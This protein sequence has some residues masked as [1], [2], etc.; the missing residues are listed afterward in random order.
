MTLEH[1]EAKG[2]IGGLLKEISSTKPGSLIL[3]NVYQA[4]P[5]SLK[6][7]QR[8]KPGEYD[9]GPRCDRLTLADRA[10][11]QCWAECMEKD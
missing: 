9:T 5:S 1:T 3:A 2:L 8:E 4:K 10:C 7:G 6:S 11:E